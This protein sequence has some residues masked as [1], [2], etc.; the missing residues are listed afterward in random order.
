MKSFIT[1]LII[2]A[3]L[4][5]F[6]IFYSHKLKAVSDMLIQETDEIYAA[7]LRDDFSAAAD[8]TR[9][10]DGNVNRLEPFLAIFGNHEDV[11]LIEG[12]LAELEVYARDAAKTDALASARYIANLFEHMP[13][14]LYIRLENIL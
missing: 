3:L 7:L 14:N 11:T 12:N 9:R 8:R 4:C 10:L 6:S 13:E 2:A 1:A 5:A